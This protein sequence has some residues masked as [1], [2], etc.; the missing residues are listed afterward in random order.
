LP[1]AAITGF[2]VGAVGVG[3][4]AAFALRKHSLDADV[5]RTCRRNECPG[6]P[7]NLEREDAANAAGLV[8]TIAF[9]GAGAGVATAV[10]LLLLDSD[11]PAAERPSVA[12]VAPWLGLGSAGVRGRF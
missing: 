11:A 6:T 1:W 8:A 12:A 7:E 5:E 2:G 9:I 4:G 10:T 3:V